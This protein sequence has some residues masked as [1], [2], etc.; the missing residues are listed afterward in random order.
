MKTYSDG[1]II[2]NVIVDIKLFIFPQYIFHQDANL[3]AHPRKLLL[4]ALIQVRVR[5]RIRVTC[6][7]VKNFILD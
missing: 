1:Y 6:L 4:H 2:C 3:F 5:V 7:A